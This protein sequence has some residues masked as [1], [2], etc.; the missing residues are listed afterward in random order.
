MSLRLEAV[1]LPVLAVWIDARVFLLRREARWNRPKQR[2][3]GDGD[4]DLIESC[5]DCRRFGLSNC[6]SLVASLLMGAGT[7]L[8]TVNTR[9]NPCFGA[10]SSSGR[11]DIGTASGSRLMDSATEPTVLTKEVE[12]SGRPGLS[13][14]P[15]LDIEPL[16]FDCVVMRGL[17]VPNA[18]LRLWPLE[19]L[20]EASF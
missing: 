14:I 2:S 16:D 13:R 1:F 20:G 5:F 17:R 4:L 18:M 9:K 8:C 3:P 6:V 15:R 12:F 11:V 10:S 19:G 7:M